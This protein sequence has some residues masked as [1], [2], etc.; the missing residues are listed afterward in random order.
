MSLSEIYGHE[1]NLSKAI[2]SS[3]S[4]GSQL[5]GVTPLLIPDLTSAMTT[6]MNAMKR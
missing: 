2:A 4:F 5:P 6:V 3:E 1:E